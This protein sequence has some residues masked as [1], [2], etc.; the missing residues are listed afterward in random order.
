MRQFIL[1]EVFTPRSKAYFVP[2][3]SQ[4]IM[5]F[6]RVCLDP[7]FLDAYTDV[8]Y[9]RYRDRYPFQ[10]G[11]M[12][13]AAIPLV[14]A[15]VMKM[16]ERGMP[17]NGFFIRKSRKKT[18]LLKMIEGQLT[19][20][21][22]ILVDDL[23]NR[24]YTLDR[25]LAVLAE[26]DRKVMSFFTLLRFRPLTAY[27]KH[28]DEGIVI[29]GLFGLDEFAQTLGTQLM[30]VDP[31]LPP[32]NFD[33]Q[34]YFRSPQAKLDAVHPKSGVVFDADRVYFGSDQGIVHAL[35]RQHG[36][37]VWRHQ[38]GLG[39]R[40]PRRDRQVF[41]SPLLWGGRLYFGA[42]DGNVYCLEAQTG[43]R[44]WVS[45]EADWIHGAVAFSAKQRSLYVPTLLGEPGQAG[46]VAILDPS[47][48]S[49]RGQIRLR[50]RVGAAPLVSDASEQLIVAEESGLVSSYN[51]ATHSLQWSFQSNGAVKETPHYDVSGKQII[52][53]SFDGSVYALNSIDGSLLWRFEVGAA[54]Y[55][56][57]FLEGDRVF[58]ASLDKHIYA[59]DRWSGKLLWTFR[60]RARVFASPRVWAGRLYCGGNDARLYELDP[61]TGRQTGFFQAVERITNAVAFDATTHDFFL[62]TYANEVYCL[63]RKAAQ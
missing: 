21:P 1:D 33:V 3:A 39:N 54:N 53:S 7:H 29:D 63:R 30:E 47:T 24:G 49:G 36:Q 26:A 12:E 56:A 62:T 14:T 42:Y 59:L 60:T 51:L 8:F 18:G 27:Q 35:D 13:V 61:A 45:F 15:I 28:T 19:N 4:W 16:R 46:G 50:S 25:Q 32:A 11:G 38:I 20:D 55:S 58:V 43:K 44:L 57:P 2:E 5:D 37:S 52:F 34:W 31:V 9:E 17:V 41:A 40:R 48:G 22:V 6:R 23:I 10:V